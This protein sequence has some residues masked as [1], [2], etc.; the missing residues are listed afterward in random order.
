MSLFLDP[1]N[2]LKT[3]KVHKCALKTLKNCRVHYCAHRSTTKYMHKM[4]LTKVHKC[5]AIF[6]Q[7]HKCG[8]IKFVFYQIQNDHLLYTHIVYNM[9]INILE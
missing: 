3:V 5:A 2:H 9:H 7:V 4:Y 1:K 6:Y 8:L